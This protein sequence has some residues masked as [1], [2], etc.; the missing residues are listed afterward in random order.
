MGLV[1]SKISGRTGRPH[2]PLFSENSDEISFMWYKKVGTRFFRFF[3]IQAFDRR[4]DRQTDRQ[5]SC[6]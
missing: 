1:L 5:L 3:T 6:S 2:E 4:A